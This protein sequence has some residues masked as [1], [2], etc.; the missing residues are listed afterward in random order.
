MN[1]FYCDFCKV[2]VHKNSLWKHNKSDKHIN[3]QRCE[4]IENYDDIVEILEGLFKE[5]PVRGFVNPFHLKNPLGDEYNE[6]ITHHNPIDLNSELKV[7]GKYFQQKSQYHINNIVKQMAIKYGNFI[8]Q[9]KFTIKVY[10]NVRYEKYPEDEPT[11][12]INHH[13]PVDIITN[14]TRILLNDLDI[15]SDLDNETQGREMQGREK[16]GSGWEFTR[17]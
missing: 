5:K 4:Q 8:K 1:K 17:Y 11:E 15:M 10:A 14:L 9:F 12:V 7:V 16:Q 2:Y 3:N 6:I 13:I